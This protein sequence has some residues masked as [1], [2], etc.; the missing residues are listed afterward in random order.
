M[1]DKF[2]PLAVQRRNVAQPAQ[3]MPFRQ[4][5]SVEDA[6]V[7]RFVN[8]AKNAVKHTFEV[9]NADEQERKEMRTAIDGSGGIAE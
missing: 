5:Q 2:I 8:D 6:P 9:P 1:S 3:K 4:T 7:S